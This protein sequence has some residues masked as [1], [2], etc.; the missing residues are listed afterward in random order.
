LQVTDVVAVAKAL[1]ASG[2]FEVVTPSAL[3]AVLIFC[4]LFPNSP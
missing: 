4:T 3:L 2:H 1:E